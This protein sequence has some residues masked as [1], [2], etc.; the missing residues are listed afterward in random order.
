[1]TTPDTYMLNPSTNPA[2][3]KFTI[4]V[5]IS[6]EIQGY[7]ESYLEADRLAKS[8]TT[9]TCST[10][11]CGF[12][13]T[14]QCWKCKANLCPAHALKV[15]RGFIYC[16]LCAPETKA[17]SNHSKKTTS[18]EPI[19]IRTNMQNATRN[20]LGIQAWYV[21]TE[22]KPAGS[23][24]TIRRHQG[25]VQGPGDLVAQDLGFFEYALQAEAAVNQAATALVHELAMLAAA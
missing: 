11:A 22:E 24:R 20:E 8:I 9:P 1:M 19:S 7:A 2:T 6:G 13:A 14:Y 15:G 4:A 17:S 12:K 3:G 18:H 5:I 16:G 23:R 25:F 21:T 10:P